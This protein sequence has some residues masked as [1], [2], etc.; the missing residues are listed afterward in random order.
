MTVRVDTSGLQRIAAR[1]TAT[2]KKVDQAKKRAQATLVR[3]L[4]AET[5][6]EVSRVQ[7]NL[8]PTAISPHILVNQGTVDG[9]AYVAVSAAKKRLPLSAFKARITKKTGATV[10][11]WRDSAP[12][13]LPHGFRR[14]KEVWQ[15]APYKGQKGQTRTPLGLVQRLPIVMRKGP[16]LKRA[17]QKVGPSQNDHGREEVVA[18]LVE[19]GQSVLAAEIQRLLALK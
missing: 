12:Y 6:R 3:R 14:G 15:R 5:A 17:L 18:H 16:S 13:A 2:G 9:N 8:S 4:K 19:Y 1:I 11:T 10:T 7:L